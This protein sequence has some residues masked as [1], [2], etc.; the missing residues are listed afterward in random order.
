[1]QPLKS[2]KEKEKFF[3]SVVFGPRDRGD[4]V[5]RAG[6][7]RNCHIVKLHKNSKWPDVSTLAES[8]SKAKFSHFSLRERLC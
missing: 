8:F 7:S 2:Y 3:Q 1:M 4:F 6:S 5:D